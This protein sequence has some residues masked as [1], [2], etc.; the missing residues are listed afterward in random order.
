MILYWPNY[1]VTEEDAVKTQSPVLG[2]NA[3]KKLGE[4]AAWNFLAAKNPVFDLT[5]INPDIII[6]P[7]LQPVDGPE[8]VNETNS[9]AVY[10]FFNGKYTDIEHLTF[11]FY[12][13]VGFTSPLRLVKSPWLLI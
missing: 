3:S 11:P 4:Q 8:H 5:V 10:N 12:H 2:Y 1:Q 6:G 7:M 9:F 13:F